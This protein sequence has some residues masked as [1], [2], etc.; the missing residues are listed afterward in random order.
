MDT[1]NLIILLLTIAVITAIAVSTLSELLAVFL[2]K[3][4]EPSVHKIQRKYFDIDRVRTGAETMIGSHAI[5]VG[6]SKLDN[7]DFTG[8][9]VIEGERW[10]ALSEK[11]IEEGS[12]VSI[13]AREKLLLVVEPIEE[14]ISTTS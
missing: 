12:T 4:V 9:V 3:F 1:S 5:A 14:S 2:Q 8:C 10:T 7:G 13:I 6:F 11:P